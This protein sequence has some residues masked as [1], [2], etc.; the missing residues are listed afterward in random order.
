MTDARAGAR[1]ERAEGAHNGHLVGAREE[2]GPDWGSGIAA[3]VLLFSM[4][5]HT[6]AKARTATEGQP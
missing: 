1:C 2:R 4:A 3:A 5:G 6:G